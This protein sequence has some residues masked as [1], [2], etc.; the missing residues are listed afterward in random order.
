[1]ESVTLTGAGSATMSYLRVNPGVTSTYG[2]GVAGPVISV[3]GVIMSADAHV[4]RTDGVV[5]DTFLGLGNGLD[6]Y[7]MGLQEQE[8]RSRQLDNDRQQ[9][10]IDRLQLAISLVKSGNAAGAELYQRLFPVPQIVNQIE[11]A[12]INSSPN[13]SPAPAP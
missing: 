3:P 5:V 8:V 6:D 4:M 1:V 11:Q 7:S 2:T 12:A 13:G 9:A 10:E